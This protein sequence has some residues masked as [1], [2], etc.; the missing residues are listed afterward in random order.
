MD[1]NELVSFGMTKTEA[2][3]YLEISKLDETKIGPIIKRTGLHR[4]TVYNAI[5][6]LIEKGFYAISMDYSHY[7]DNSW[8][9]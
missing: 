5:N 1:V 8:N 4:G 6:D 9:Q 2:K 7:I 3:I